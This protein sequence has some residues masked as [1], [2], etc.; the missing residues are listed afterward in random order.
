MRNIFALFVALLTVTYPS[1]GQESANLNDV[2][3]GHTL[4]IDV[5]AN[6]HVA[7]PD[8]PDKP[9]LRQP[10]PSFESIAQRESVNEDWLHNY[11][12]TTHRGLDNPKGMPNPRLLEFQIKQVAAY[13]LSLRK[14][15]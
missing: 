4:A 5:C 6:C 14:N 2:R 12:K 9:I 11:L 15:H 1:W 7:A 3:A 8:Q 13:L 10:A